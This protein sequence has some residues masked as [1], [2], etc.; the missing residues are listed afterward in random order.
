LVVLELIALTMPVVQVQLVDG[1]VVSFVFA[2]IADSR[3]LIGPGGFAPAHLIGGLVFFAVEQMDR[4][5]RG[6]AAGSL[7]E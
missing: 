3:Y 1:I 7:A 6:Q 5:E 2:K 4:K